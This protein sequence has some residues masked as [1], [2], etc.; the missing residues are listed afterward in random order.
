MSQ[1]KANKPSDS[2]REQKRARKRARQQRPL[3]HPAFWP[4]WFGLGCLRLL[5]WLPHAAQLQLGRGLGTCFFHLAKKRR[6]ITLVNIQLCFPH[7]SAS[8]QLTLTRQ[9]LQAMCIGLL[10]VGMCWWWS[11]KRLENMANI[12]GLEHLD[13]ALAKGKGV[14]LLSGH[15]TTLEVSG[16]LLSLQRNIDAMF[17]PH[18]NPV[19][20]W[21]MQR[22]RGEHAGQAI[23]RQDLRSVL[24]AL[25]KNHA[26]WYAPDQS[27]KFKQHVLAPFFGEPAVCNTAT[28]KL[29]KLTGAAVV[30][31]FGWRQADGSY[32]L[33]LLPALLDFPSGDD[34]A[35]A[36]RVNQV[37]ETAI[38]Q[39]PE[40]Y[41]WA[42]E[43]FKKRGGDLP[44][45]YAKK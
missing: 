23:P 43:R 35:D 11:P 39:A 6:N 28:A 3:W 45:V 2:A 7:L 29:S 33:E 30:P 34:I 24:R 13:T 25:R 5:A 16:R 4:T 1:P 12:R 10:E 38:L 21:A 40:Q 31:F 18:D 9:H 8:E 26:V 36:T 32:Q 19:L 15:F 44:N 22:F 17:R 37:I 14:L 41:L 27:K 20:A 42:H